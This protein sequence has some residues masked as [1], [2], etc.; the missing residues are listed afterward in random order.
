[1]SDILLNVVARSLETVLSILFGVNHLA[2]Q[3]T[4]PKH[5][6]SDSHL[7]TSPEYLRNEDL[8]NL[9]ELR[10][11]ILSAKALVTVDGKP[12]GGE[13]GEDRKFKMFVEPGIRL[14]EITQPGF[15]PY[16]FAVHSKPQMTLIIPP[17]VF[18]RA[19]AVQ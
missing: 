16:K 9:C 4:E 8:G 14:I 12:I 15:Y 2:N 18:E 11:P 6:Q 5:Q 7:E 17:I 19:T 3:M 13:P 1:M 10:L